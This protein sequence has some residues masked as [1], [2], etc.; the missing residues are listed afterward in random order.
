M[1]CLKQL[2]IFGLESIPEIKPGDDISTIILSSCEKEKIRLETNDLIL[3][4]S[5][6]VSKAENSLADLEKI[7]PGRKA[8]AIAKLTGKDPTEVEIILSQATQ[9]FAVIPVEKVMQHYPEIFYNLSTDK[10]AALRTVHKVPSMLVTITKQGILATDAGLDYSNNPFGKASLLPS[11]PNSSAKKIRDQ[12]TKQTGKD[13]SVVITDTEIAFTN[14]Y[15]S[16]E[17]AIGYSG[18]RP[19]AHRFASKDRFGREKFGGADVIVDELACAAALLGGQTSEGIP[20]VIVRGLQYEKLEGNHQL[21]FP[22]DALRKGFTWS[23]LATLK[24]R[25]FTMVAELFA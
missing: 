16:T 19:V 13:V 11:D 8:R 14:I 2:S 1:N 4:T 21:S 6:I 15:G 10:E 5:K 20:V 18:I 7:V 17:I 12:L 24:L 22:V 9:I 25:L 3:I 23:M